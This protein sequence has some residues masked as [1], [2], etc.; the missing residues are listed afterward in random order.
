M[1][2]WLTTLFR[3]KGP[4]HDFPKPNSVQ[5]WVVGIDRCWFCLRYDVNREKYTNPPCPRRRPSTV[6]LA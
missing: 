5:E 1:I 4:P 6:E 2:K 3:P